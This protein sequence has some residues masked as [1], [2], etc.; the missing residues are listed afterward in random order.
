MTQPYK[1]R[2]I[3]NKVKFGILIDWDAVRREYKKLK[4]PKEYHYPLK[5]DFGRVGYVIDMSD[6]SRGKTTNKLIV[7]LLLY[8]M[9]GIQLHYVRQKSSQCEIPEQLR[10]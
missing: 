8:A 10:L 9:Y 3:Q 5:A 6:R 4:I 2:Y 1:I 7:G